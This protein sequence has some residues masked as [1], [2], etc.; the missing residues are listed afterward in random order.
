MNEFDPSRPRFYFSL[1]RLMAMLRGADPTRAETNGTEAWLAGVA[2]YLIGFLFFAQFI[3]VDLSA[4][5]T[6][7]ALVVLAF[8]VWLFWLLVLY[9]NSLIIRLL[10]PAGFFQSI[11]TRRAQSILLGLWATTMAFDLARRGSWMGEVAAIWLVAVALNL[12]AA[13]ILAF[14]NGARTE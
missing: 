10:R 8:L 7:L 13:A 2:M 11:P 14:H 9:F 5:L 1:L 6:A 12:A 3:P 4:W